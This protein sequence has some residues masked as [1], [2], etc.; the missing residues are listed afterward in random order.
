MRP[1]ACPNQC[2][3][4]VDEIDVAVDRSGHAEATAEIGA[5]RHVALLKDRA[6][7]AD[8]RRPLDHARKAD[9]D[10]RDLGDVEARVADAAAHAVFHQVGDDGG[11]LAIDADRQRERAQDVGAEIGYRDRDL[12][13]RE[14]DADHM[15]RVRI[16]LEHDARP[17]ASRVAHG[18]ELQRDDEPVV[19]Q[20]RRDRRD[21]GRDSVPSAARFRPARRDQSGGSRP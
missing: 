13:V 8:A 16:E 1:R 3:A 9:A 4:R 12:V 19:E 21:G 2:S 11:R 15:R 6:L 14:L 20:R 5:E 18:A 7:P 17:A 10:A